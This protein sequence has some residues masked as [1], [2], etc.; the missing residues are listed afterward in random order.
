MNNLDSDLGGLDGFSWHGH[1]CSG[2]AAG[3]QAE[4]FFGMA[5][6]AALDGVR[7]VRVFTD[8]ESDGDSSVVAEDD[9]S[10]EADISDVEDESVLNTILERNQKYL[11]AAKG[12][13]EVGNRKLG[14]GEDILVVLKP[15]ASKMNFKALYPT[16]YSGVKD[17]GG[18]DFLAKTV[19]APSGWEKKSA[20]LVLSNQ[21]I[22]KCF[23][24]FR[25]LP[26][27]TSEA[28]VSAQL[29][30]LVSLVATFLD[31]EITPRQETP[32]SVGGIL[33]DPK[34]YLKSNTD[35]HFQ[36]DGRTVIATIL[37]KVSAFPEGAVWYRDSRGVQA[38]TAMYAHDAPTFLM[39]HKQW[40]LI[41][42]NE[43]RDCVLTYP[44]DMAKPSTCVKQLGPTFLQAL[45]ICMLSDPSG[46]KGTKPLLPASEAVLVQTPE[47]KPTRTVGSVEHASKRPRPDS[48]QGNDSKGAGGPQYLHSSSG[49]QT[50][51]Q[52][53]R[54]LSAEDVRIIENRIAAA[55]HTST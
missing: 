54:V 36:I 10:T 53:V 25:D 38:I 40:K 18:L 3:R 26:G 52:R 49:G 7:A 35:I 17:L 29:N 23:Q 11:E 15:T 30:H 14:S 19:N 31:V 22:I 43:N 6:F 32:V 4:Y 16:V 1:N 21:Q 5:T 13:W 33:V 28:D 50:V 12:N 51:F 27:D 34:Y 9:L 48:S 20:D 39:T 45:C 24:K 2:P 8:T 55:E 46:H 37:K 47:S 44:F 41:V 42:Q